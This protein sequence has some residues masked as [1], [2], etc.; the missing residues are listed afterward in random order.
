MLCA[1]QWKNF[2]KASADDSSKVC[3]SG[4]K[5]AHGY[6]V[7]FILQKVIESSV[8]GCRPVPI[9]LISI[10]STAPVSNNWT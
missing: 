9:K 3:F 2:G 5:D 1:M 4:E 8:L 6:R 7:G 10:R